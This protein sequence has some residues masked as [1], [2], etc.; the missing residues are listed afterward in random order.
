MVSKQVARC[1]P[2][3]DLRTITDFQNLDMIERLLECLSTLTPPFNE[4]TEVI[5]ASSV[6]PDLK[7]YLPE[8]VSTPAPS[9]LSSVSTPY[10][11]SDQPSPTRYSPL[12][13]LNPQC[14]QTEGRIKHKA[15]VDSRRSRYS[16]AWEVLSD[17]GASLIS[18]VK[19]VAKDG[20][21][22]SWK[23]ARNGESLS[24]FGGVGE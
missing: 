13:D 18:P 3:P 17:S 19:E 5:D 14:P 11:T 10:P 16:D 12:P 9:T 15:S 23:S 24:E 7:L 8:P 4:N 22:S 21:V 1:V 6:G 20:S 2:Y